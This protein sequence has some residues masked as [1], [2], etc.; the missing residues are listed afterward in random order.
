MSG[1]CLEIRAR[2]SNDRFA[3]DVVIIWGLWVAVQGDRV[4]IY[5]SCTVRWCECIEQEA[6]QALMWT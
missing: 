4:V 2:L 6:D 1:L 5:T 3:T